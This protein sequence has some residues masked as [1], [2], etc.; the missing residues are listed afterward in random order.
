MKYI[1]LKRRVSGEGERPTCVTLAW[2]PIATDKYTDV[3]ALPSKVCTVTHV[4]VATQ[5]STT[6][7]LEPKP[8]RN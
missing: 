2:C 7:R 4:G 8:S 3:Y 1:L 5:I 6:E